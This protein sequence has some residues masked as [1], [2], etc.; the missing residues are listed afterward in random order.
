MYEIAI[1]LIF[2]MVVTITLGTVLKGCSIRKCENHWFS[3][4]VAREKKGVGR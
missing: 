4:L 1:E 3:S 2:W